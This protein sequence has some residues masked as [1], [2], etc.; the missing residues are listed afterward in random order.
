MIMTVYTSV[1]SLQY[2]QYN[3]LHPY[4]MSLPAFYLVTMSF[5]VEPFGFRY[6]AEHP[7]PSRAPAYE[8]A[9][10]MQFGINCKND[11]TV[12]DCA[13]SLYP[14]LG[15]MADAKAELCKVFSIRIFEKHM[16]NA[17]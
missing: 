9:I 2:S 6:I 17:Y 4:N 1:V 13:Y 8:T 10:L 7:A 3:I 11:R 5:E 16:E 12:G 15:H 14:Q